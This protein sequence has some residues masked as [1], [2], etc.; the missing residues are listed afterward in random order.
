M[1]EVFIANTDIANIKLKEN[2]RKNI[3]I[4]TSKVCMLIKKTVM[5][6]IL[7]HDKIKSMHYPINKLYSQN[8]KAK[9]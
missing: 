4:Y 2:V 6:I 8:K 5:F 9:H 1:C 3:E 7:F